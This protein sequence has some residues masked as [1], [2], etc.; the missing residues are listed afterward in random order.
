MAQSAE[1]LAQD[2]ER[3]GFVVVP[4]FLDPARVAKARDEI[5]AWY[6]RDR[7]ERKAGA[8]A[9]LHEGVAGKSILRHDTHLMLD[10]YGT[11]PTLDA[12]F[13]QILTD[14]RSAAIL[15]ALAGRNLKLRRRL[16]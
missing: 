4:G 6:R 2:L 14:A 11:S 16:A 1:S 12:L 13:E 9:E 5:D 8:A 10:V 3:D 15:E 7:E